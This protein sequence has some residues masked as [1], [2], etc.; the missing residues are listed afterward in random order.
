[1]EASSTPATP[2][3]TRRASSGSTGSAA[4]HLITSPSPHP[5]SHQQA[6]PEQR[7]G[8]LERGYSPGAQR[9]SGKS[10]FQKSQVLFEA[11]V[12]FTEM[13]EFI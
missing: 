2:T 10:H 9:K 5:S 7:G 12:G 1:M 4:H 8:S 6:H 3:G 11:L 13:N